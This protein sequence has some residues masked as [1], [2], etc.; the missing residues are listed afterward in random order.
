MDL[1]SSMQDQADA[2]LVI[3]HF[4]AHSCHINLTPTYQQMLQV[5]P[6]S[7]QAAMNL[8][9]RLRMNCLYNYAQ[10]HNYLVCGTSN[11]AE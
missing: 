6:Q 5:C 10:A 3:S 8:K 1:E 4:Q 2:N 7:K 9:A 11:G